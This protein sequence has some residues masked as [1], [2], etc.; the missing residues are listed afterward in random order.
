MGVNKKQVQASFLAL[1]RKQ[2][3]KQ[4]ER[5]RIKHSKNRN[6]NNSNDKDD[7]DEDEDDDEEDDDNEEDDNG[8]SDEMILRMIVDKN[9]DKITGILGS[10][11]Y[12]KVKYLNLKYYYNILNINLIPYLKAKS[13]F[14]QNSYRR[15]S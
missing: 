14:Y 1:Q 13:Y 11:D 4:L 6:R 15:Y 8:I 12:K 5:K 3:R 10:D 7:E 9:I 2:A